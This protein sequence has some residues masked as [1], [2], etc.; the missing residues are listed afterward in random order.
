M[1][2]RQTFSK[3]S[4]HSFPFSGRKKFS[5]GGTNLRA[6]CCNDKKQ[7]VFLFPVIHGLELPRSLF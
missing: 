7:I 6:I 5:L 4:C 1:R 3:G 2:P